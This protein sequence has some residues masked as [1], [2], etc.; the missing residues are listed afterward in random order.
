MHKILVAAFAACLVVAVLLSGCGG[1]TTAAPTG[2]SA[3]QSSTTTAAGTETTEAQGGQP[4][5][6]PIVIGAVVS[7]TGPNAPLG[8]P[9]RMALELF[10]KQINAAGGVLGR[11]LSVVILD[12]QSNAKEAVTATQRLL[13]QEKA[14]AVIGGSGSAST[15]A[16]KAIT[17]QAGIPQIAMAASNSITAEPPSD[18]IWRVAP[19]DDLAVERAVSYVAKDLQLAKVAVLYDENAFGSSGLAQIEKVKGQYGIEVVAKESYKTDETDLTAQLTKLKGSNPEALIVWGTNPGP[20]VAAK[21]LK[22]LGWDVPYVGSHGIANAKF[23]ELAADAA[24]GVAFPTTKI[25]FPESITDPAQKALI[26]KLIAD[27]TAEFGQAPNH[28]S[29]HGWDGIAV[30]VAAIEQAK[31]TEPAALQAA[32]NGLTDFTGADGIFTYTATD[33]D[34]LKVDDL[35]MVKIEGGKWVL[36]Q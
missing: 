19:K 26:D 30:L 17:A 9:E 5:G 14:V 36:A 18:W 4:S 28:F 22:Q 7:T 8:E 33:H 20:A 34:G 31:S 1:T 16:M 15:L 12:D 13:Q 25:L 24:E 27:Y 3:G 32:L 29:S 11:P 23:I 10:E 6:D 35:I 2:T 21:N